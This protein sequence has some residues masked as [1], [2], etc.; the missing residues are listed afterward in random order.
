M[1]DLLASPPTLDESVGTGQLTFWQR[2]EHLA[3]RDEWLCVLRQI[4]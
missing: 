4:T 3:T 1:A 2:I